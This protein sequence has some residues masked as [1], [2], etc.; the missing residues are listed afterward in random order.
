MP[1]MGSDDLC[2]NPWKYQGWD[3]MICVIIPEY[4][5]NGIRYFYNPLI[6]QGEIGLCALTKKRLLHHDS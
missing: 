5:K 3:Q 6:Y 1:G 4:T 2:N